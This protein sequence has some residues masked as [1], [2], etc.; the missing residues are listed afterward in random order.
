MT[1]LP[2]HCGVLDIYDLH[3]D[4]LQ[5]MNNK[6]KSCGNVLLQFNS[7]A[8]CLSMHLGRFSDH[9]ADIIKGEIGWG[10]DQWDVR[11]KTS[12]RNRTICTGVETPR[13]LLDKGISN[14]E[15]SVLSV[16]VSCWTNSQIVVIQDI[17]MLVWRHCNG[18]CTASFLS[19]S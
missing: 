19:T 13:E 3:L 10:I 15:F 6:T 12:A 14:A 4:H 8:K 7:F 2:N 18:Q 9:C 1:S 17:L 11:Q 16:W 5:Y